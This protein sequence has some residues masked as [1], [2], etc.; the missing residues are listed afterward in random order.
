[1]N[2]NADPFAVLPEAFRAVL[3]NPRPLAVYI[4]IAAAAVSVRLAATHALTGGE[5]PEDPELP[6]R[7]F[8]LGSN[9]AL[10]GIWAFTQT[11]VFSWLG[12]ELDRPLWR[13]KGLRDAL[14]RFFVLWLI[15]NL[16]IIVFA[17]NAQR[18]L[19]T[20]SGQPGGQFMAMLLLLI[21]MQVVAIPFG[22]A[23]M[24]HGELKWEE[25]AE[26][27]SPLGRQFPATVL[28]MGFSGA[29]LVILLFIVRPLMADHQWLRPF[30]EIPSGLAECVIFTA[31]W[32]ICIM[33]RDAEHADNDFDF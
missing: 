27:L 16:L 4:G 10:A 33:D 15:L 12:Q 26:S 2:P 24:F 13:V 25:L 32:R 28:V 3:R 30:I 11:L 23:V 7:L 29:V 19:E 8:Q 6:W 22:A 20:G 14:A 18:L 5:I 9:L 21:L 31:T 1:M 17:V